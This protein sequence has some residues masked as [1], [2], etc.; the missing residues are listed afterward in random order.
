ML[1]RTIVK[2]IFGAFLGK[3]KIY[4]ISVKFTG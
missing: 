4:A 3:A 2:P 1:R